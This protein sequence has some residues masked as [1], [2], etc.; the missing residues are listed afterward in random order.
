MDVFAKQAQINV[1]IGDTF[2]SGAP[3]ADIK[4]VIAYGVQVKTKP[5]TVI[6][7]AKTRN[8]LNM[9]F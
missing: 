8:L 9:H 5:T 2:A 4:K 7:M 6:I 1:A 3:N